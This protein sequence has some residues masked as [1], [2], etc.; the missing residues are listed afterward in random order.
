LNAFSLSIHDPSEVILI[1]CFGFGA[2]ETF[3]INVE[4]FFG[5]G[6]NFVSGLFEE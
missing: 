1:C 2:Q 5:N 6:D 3:L 4:Y